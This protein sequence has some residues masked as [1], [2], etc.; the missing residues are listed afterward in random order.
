MYNMMLFLIEIRLTTINKNKPAKLVNGC[1][2]C[3]WCICQNSTWIS[4]NLYG[5]IL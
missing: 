4:E 2:R 5:R 1:G 3:W